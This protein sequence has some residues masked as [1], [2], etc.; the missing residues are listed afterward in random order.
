MGI[1]M[2]FPSSVKHTSRNQKVNVGVP[3]PLLLPMA[4][5]VNLCWTRGLVV[6]GDYAAKVS[7]NLS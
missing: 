1:N 7:L 5:L 3:S 4:H 6:K 2:L